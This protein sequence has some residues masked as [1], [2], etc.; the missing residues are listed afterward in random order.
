MTQEATLSV[1]ASPGLTQA[2]AKFTREL[3]AGFIDLGQGTKLK[4]RMPLRFAFE[5]R[6]YGFRLTPDE[7]IAVERNGVD[8]WLE[9]IDFYFDGRIVAGLHLI[10]SFEKEV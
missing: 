3:G 10:V 6:P 8:P 5:P 7:R 4:V 2:I 1:A 9:Y